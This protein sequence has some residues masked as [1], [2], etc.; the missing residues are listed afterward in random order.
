M[1]TSNTCFI[2]FKS[3][4]Q[5]SIVLDIHFCKKAKAEKGALRTT[6][7]KIIN[8][9]VLFVSLGFQAKRAAC[10]SAC[11]FFAGDT[12]NRYGMY[13]RRA[14]TE[15]YISM[16]CIF[17][18]WQHTTYVPLQSTHRGHRPTNQPIK[19]TNNQ[20]YIQN[21]LQPKESIEQ[22]TSCCLLWC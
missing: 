13:D 11:V 22:K 6:L 21:F 12:K 20:T 19:H 14:D 15:R 3:T 2:C 7:M 10:S 4:V 18:N 17:I 9:I 5:Y 8:D 1:F 16:Q